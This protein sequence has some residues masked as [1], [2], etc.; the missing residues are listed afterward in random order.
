VAAEEWARRS[1]RALQEVSMRFADL[2]TWIRRGVLDAN[3][4]KL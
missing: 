4:N 1:A 2:A 3:E